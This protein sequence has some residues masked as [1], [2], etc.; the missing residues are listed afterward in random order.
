MLNGHKAFRNV[1]TIDVGK[2][3]YADFICLSF[4]FYPNTYA[5]GRFISGEEETFGFETP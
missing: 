2:T 1:F 5:G 3:D 4:V